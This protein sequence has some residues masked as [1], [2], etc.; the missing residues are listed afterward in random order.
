MVGGCACRGLA[1]RRVCVFF[2]LPLGTG[3]LVMSDDGGLDEV[4][5]FFSR[6]AIRSC[7]FENLISHLL[8]E[9]LKFFN[10]LQ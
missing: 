4:E 5:E 1:G 8:V 2:F 7:K 9:Q 10:P 6:R 3:G